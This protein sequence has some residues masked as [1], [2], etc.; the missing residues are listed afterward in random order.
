MSTLGRC[1]DCKHWSVW[2]KGVCDRV[3]QLQSD[4]DSR[5]EVD[6]DVL[7]DSGLMVSLEQALSLDVHTSRRKTD[8][9]EE[10]CVCT[11]CTT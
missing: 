1:K 5:F 3:E 7:D 6:V 8:A 4:P 2:F 11:T 9:Y 10:R